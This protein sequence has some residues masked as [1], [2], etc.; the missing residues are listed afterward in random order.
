MKKYFN[1]KSIIALVMAAALAFTGCSST[2]DKN[3]KTQDD[4]AKLTP[5]SLVLT[6]GDKTVNYN[7]AGFYIMA[8]KQQ[9][10]SISPNIWSQTYSG[11]QT[12]EDLAKQDVIDRLTMYKVIEQ[13]APK[14]KVSL[15]DDEKSE[16]KK[17]VADSLKSISEE[18][19]KKF[20][21]TESILQ[22]IGEDGTLA[23]KVFEKVTADVDTKISDDEAKQITIQHMLIKTKKT[24]DGKEVDMTEQEKAK[25]KKKAEKLL[26]EAKKTKDFKKLAEKNTE[27][28]QVEYTFGKGKMVKEFEE[29]AFKMKKGEVSDI[30]ETE[31]GY[32]I[33]YCVSDY[34]KEATD[35]QKE[36]LVQE[37][38]NKAFQEKVEEWKKN[39]KIQVNDKIWDQVKFVTD[40]ELKAAEDAAKSAA[41][42]TPAASV[43]PSASASPSATPAA[44]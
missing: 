33:L 9:Y 38:Q 29:A 6:V 44:K 34:D 8:T 12:F 40:E 23:N 37:K 11:D 2:G 10:G 7:E 20:G 21:F 1:K 32:H 28:S 14:L 26:K 42:G 30:V 16:V 41:S 36:T 15:T 5:E 43:S 17:K 27:D 3:K 39:Y 4:K 22:V 24:K 25:A 19:Q 35:K 13:E 31:Y 18:D